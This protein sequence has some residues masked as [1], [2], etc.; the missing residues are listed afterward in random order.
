MY[1]VFDEFFNT[2]LDA[3]KFLMIGIIW[4]SRDSTSNLIEGY[5]TSATSVR[6]NHVI[7]TFAFSYA[8]VNLV[9]VQNYTDK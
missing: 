5:N 6:R 2:A 4:L 8:Y 3:V 7:I 1:M 9:D